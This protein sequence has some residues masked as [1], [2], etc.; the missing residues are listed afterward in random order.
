MTWFP[1]HLLR[2]SRLLIKVRQVSSSRETP[3]PAA[4]TIVAADEHRAPR[5]RMVT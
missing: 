2:A 4:T 3:S 5:V 1:R